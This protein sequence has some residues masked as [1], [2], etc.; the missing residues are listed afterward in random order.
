MTTDQPTPRRSLRHMRPGSRTDE[1]AAR[2]A[3]MIRVDHA[4]EFGA[5]RIYEGQLAVF[6]HRPGKERIAEIIR[7]MA[8]QEEHHKAAFDTLMVA[9]G[10]RPTALQPVWHVAGFALGAVTALIG[11]R[12]AMTCTEAVEEVID[13][14]YADQAERL[15]ESEA[16]LKSTI[17]RFR[18]DEAEH[19]DTAVEEGA[20]EA[21][22]YRALHAAIS[23]G[24]RLAI[25]LSEKI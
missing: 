8:A 20:R 14:H 22:G 2:I 16:D 19:R 13:R 25:R 17:E 12:A 9:R 4:G 11:E 23:L 5:T 3:E 1:G 15:G 21:V 6:A 7:E 10:V 18:A 24:T